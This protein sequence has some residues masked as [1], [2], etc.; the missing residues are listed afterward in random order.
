ME[1]RQKFASLHCHQSNQGGKSCLP[2]AKGPLSGVFIFV[3]TFW[4]LYLLDCIPTVSQEPPIPT[5]STL[6]TCLQVAGIKNSWIMY[7]AMPYANK[8]CRWKVGIAHFHHI[9]SM[10]TLVANREM[11]ITV[12]APDRNE[13]A[14]NNCSSHSGKASYRIKYGNICLKDL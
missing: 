11:F 1:A 13:R 5:S 3:W 4:Y 9:N 6:H 7:R 10:K 8:I 14:I 2:Q 12:W